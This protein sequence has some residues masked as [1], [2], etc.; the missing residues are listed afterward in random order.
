[1]KQYQIH[2]VDLHDGRDIWL[3]ETMTLTKD[4]HG[5]PK[6]LRAEAPVVFDSKAKAEAWLASKKH[7]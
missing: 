6:L 2:P 4:E 5:D 1:M 7:G 3:G